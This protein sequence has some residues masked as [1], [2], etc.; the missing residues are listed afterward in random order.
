MLERRL[1]SKEE[2]QAEAGDWMAV[3]WEELIGPQDCSVDR[4][5]AHGLK[6]MING[7]SRPDLSRPLEEDMFEMALDR[8]PPSRWFCW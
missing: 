2:K 4:C 6:D 5:P 8:K 3:S 7:L 1:C